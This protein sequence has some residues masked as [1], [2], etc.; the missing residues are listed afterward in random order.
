MYGGSSKH[1]RLGGGAGRGAGAAKLGRASFP[2][3]HR[4]STPAANR[5]SLGGSNNSRGGRNSAPGTSA[6]AAAPAVEEKF[7]LVS[8]NN[9]VAFSMIIRLVPDLVEEIKRV[10][11]QGGTPRIKFDSFSNNPNGNVIDV[12]GKEFRFTWSRDGD[13]CDIYEER[14]TGE[15]GNGLLVE[16]GCAWR[17]V[18]VQR[19]LD[20]STKNHVK[21]MSEEAERMH[22]SRKAIVLEQNPAMKNQL[23]QYDTTAN[24]SWRNFKHKKEPPSKK[25]KVEPPQV[26]PKSAF[27]SGVS[28]VTTA[29]G[30]PSSSPLPSTPE[31]SASPF[32]MLNI[33]KTRASADETIPSKVI[34]KD[35]PTPSLD[36]E[37]SIRTSA[38][39]ETAGKGSGRARPTDL[40]SLLITLLMENP[41]GMS[42]K[43]LEK[44]I[45]DSF[46]N[47]AKKIE[48]IL[49]KIA[50]CQVPGKYLLK[51]GVELESFKKPLFE[52]GSSPEESLR[53]TPA[54]DDICDQRPA[55]EPEIKEKVSSIEMEEQGQGHFNAT[56]GEELQA[57][58]KIDNQQQ[59]PDLFGEKRASDN[60][61]ARVASST[62]SESGSDSDSESDS[63]DSGS[64]S[65]S[66]SRS[67][68]R[69]KSPIGSGSGSSSDSDSD[70]SSNSKEVSDEDVNIMSD[71]DKEPKHQTQASEAALPVQWGT[72]DGRPAQSGNDDKQD[73]S[74]A[75]D[76]ETVEQD[77]ELAVISSSLPSEQPVIETKSSPPE[78]VEHHDR[79]NLVDSLFGKTT[80]KDD[81]R[82]EQS[83][84][85][86]RMSKGNL[87][88]GLVKH[89]DEK[90]ERRKRSKMENSSQPSA[91]LGKGV[92]FS[93]DSHNLSPDRLIEGSYKGPVSQMLNKTDRDGNTELGSQKG[94]TQAVSGRYSS[95]SKQSS[96]KSYDHSAQ[97]K[98]PEQGERP[99]RY[100]ESLGLGLQYSEKSSHVHEGFPM[101]K[102]NV[103]SSSQK[104]GYAN[105]KKVP[106]N[107]KEGGSRGKQS[108][109]LDSHYQ[110]HGDVAGKIK[111][112]RQ[113]SSVLFSSSPRE[114]RNGADRSPVVNGR[115]SKLQREVSELELGELREAVAE[116]T[117][118][119][120]QFERKNSF[121]QSEA[122]LGT[123]DN[124][125]P[126][127]SKAKP[128]GK[129]SLELGKPSSPDLNLKFPS[130][131]E[132]LVKKRKYEDRIEDLT[133]SQQRALQSQSQ[134]LSRVDHSDV[135]RPFSRSADNGGKSTH[136]E[137]GGRQGISLD[138]YGESNK[139]ASL[140]ASQHHDSKQGSL[141][142]TNKE[143][144]RPASSMVIEQ[145]DVRK[146]SMLAEGTDSDR[147]RR[148]SSSDENS[149][150]YTKY[151]K[152]EPELKGP[153]KDFS[154]YKE[155]V[156]EYRDKYDSYCSLNKILESYRNEFLKLG[157]DLEFATGTE[158]YYNIL[159][160]LKESYRQCGSRHK[161]L[162]KIFVVLHEELKHLK[163]RIKDFALPYTKD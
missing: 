22:K 31:K 126:D 42:L 38:A 5:L 99:D 76:I 162:K 163:E 56:V 51:P 141:T 142:H 40:Q 23:A 133:G 49:K 123:R 41:K 153:I 103:H 90:S 83:D 86:E 69:S 88:R 73:D 45:G 158:R 135:V 131:A 104:D 93:E 2:P 44:G 134:H 66:P 156:Q 128:A 81:F 154:Q 34:I 68:S 62:S 102:D 65:G 92:Q 155:Y 140:S 129:T 97:A 3:P 159:D 138:G 91:S 161:R 52:S 132:G 110:K 136:N 146:D 85:S 139:K 63:S 37:T 122:K 84:S 43:A 39:M 59:S 107:S 27:K 53:Q 12:G 19:I 117:P 13:L 4:S 79:Q 82:Y 8:G 26:P 114:N 98:A 144:K 47:C 32:G 116:E 74:D 137:V 94:Y 28:S 89:S 113:L 150:S 21:R 18:N 35:K 1:G 149:C 54:A 60:S 11:A 72:P 80:D 101:R 75:I 130:N 151:E 121:K 70:L 33:S 160:Q 115:A 25:Q 55:Q 17:K 106:R 120:K 152:D 15:D 96:Q 112:D 10:E 145:T 14:K 24:C 157:K 64:D 148:D 36:K 67:R 71:D 7:S 58:Q 9:P 48:S 16:S 124:W 77:T 108:V 118:V 127:F 30:R 143:S 100:S 111:E 20:E 61:E 78:H 147:K 87:K 105:E 57:F 109:P 50:N 46:P 6:S 95:E 29:K 119:K 125:A